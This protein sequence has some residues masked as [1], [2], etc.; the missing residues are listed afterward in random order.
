M[1][2][3][4]IR[5]TSELGNATVEQSFAATAQFWRNLLHPQKKFFCN[6]DAKQVGFG[7]RTCRHA[8]NIPHSFSHSRVFNCC[9]K[10]PRVSIFFF[11]FPPNFCRAGSGPRAICPTPFGMCSLWIGTRKSTR[12]NPDSF[13]IT[14]WERI[15]YSTQSFLADFQYCRVR[16]FESQVCQC[17][18]FLETEPAPFLYHNL[19]SLPLRILAT[20]LSISGM[21]RATRGTIVFSRRMRWTRWCQARVC[22]QM[23]LAGRP[24]ISTEQLRICSVNILACRNFAS[25]IESNM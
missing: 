10:S 16:M 14:R 9:R 20:I 7:S 19:Y 12:S 11:N 23:R 4:D 21:S 2:A 3:S 6:R 15:Q 24:N 25:K 22:G 1:P 17:I 18:L 8:M 13:G 5:P